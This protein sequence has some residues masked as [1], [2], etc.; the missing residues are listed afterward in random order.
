MR[1]QRRLF[2]SKSFRVLILK[3]VKLVAQGFSKSF[4]PE[5]D[6]LKGINE[7][8]P[9]SERSSPKHL[10]VEPE[11]SEK[12]LAL[13]KQSPLGSERGCA[14]SIDFCLKG[15]H[16]VAASCYFFVSTGFNSGVGNGLRLLSTDL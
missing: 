7:A 9:A 4:R 6:S 5:G 16:L 12:S 3:C 13:G 2:S 11:R 1:Y 8:A 14:V 10:L 15:M